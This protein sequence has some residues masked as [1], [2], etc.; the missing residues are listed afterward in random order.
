[1]INEM[2]ILNEY[3][4]LPIQ[5]C[6][7]EKLFEIFCLDNNNQEVKVM[8]F[9]VPVGEETKGS[10][11]YDYLARF[12]VKQ[13][14]DKTFILKGDVSEAFMKEVCNSSF[15]AYEPLRRPS[16]H[17]TAERGWINDPNG[18]VY[19]DGYYHLYYQFNPCNTEWNNM[20]WGHAVSKNLLHWV[21][22]DMVLTPDEDG[23][24]FSGSAIVNDRGLLDLPNDTIVYFYS[25]AGG[26]NH[27]GKDKLF[28]Q[29]IAYSIDQGE[30]LYKTETGKL[31]TIC[32]E[33][34]DP[35]VFWHEES[36]AYIMTLWLEKNDF[37][38]FRSID[39]KDWNMTDKIILID[40]WECPDLLKVSS[41]D[42]EY[43][44]IFWSADGYYYW[45][46]FDGYKFVTDGIKHCAYMNKLPYAAQTFSGIQDRV[47]SISWIRNKFDGR[48]YTGSMGLPRELS[49]I[50]MNGER[51]LSQQPIKELKECKSLLYEKT[52]DSIMNHSFSYQIDNE[53]SM[54]IDSIINISKQTLTR[55]YIGGI[56]I[57]YECE[58]GIFEVNGERYKIGK[59]IQDFNFL[60]DDVIF[61]V[62]AN[63]G[64]IVGVF[65]LPITK[66]LIKVELGQFE[67]FGIYQINE[68]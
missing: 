29:K 53:I 16:I 27:W 4:Y 46:E 62:T 9:M 7:E 12:P 32:K 63:H 36:Q 19:K 42:K 52:A 40:A 22:K 2:K 6:K 14:T 24:I 67:E 5:I 50:T 56:E 28:T 61:E 23:M 26:S 49:V 51:Y 10:Y 44:W 39:L 48:L 60:L 11:S 54:E 33:N 31:D 18:L 13:F 17:F 58:T 8:E 57:R 55:W 59:K 30:N 34:R 15:I 3:L 66:P 25:A 64:I 38:I 43:H 68:S 21:P 41:K 65:E 1:M 20:C 35:K 47:V 37:G 45:G